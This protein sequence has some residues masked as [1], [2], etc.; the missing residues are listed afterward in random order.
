MKRDRYGKP[1]DESDQF[2][3]EDGEELDVPEDETTSASNPQEVKG[4]YNPAILDTLARSNPALIAKYRKQIA[5][6]DDNV[7]TAKSRQRMGD[8]ANTAGDLMNDY[9]N[10]QK[11]DVILKNKMSNLGNSPSINKAT[12]PEYE[13]KISGITSRNLAQANSDRAKVDSEFKND[14]AVNELQV[15]SA[16][17]ADMNDPASGESEQARNYLKKV[18]PSASNY[19]NL[20][21]MSAAQIEKIVPGLY[22]KYADDQDNVTKRATLAKAK[23]DK[24]G[25]VDS[26]LVTSEQAIAK[27]YRSHPVTKA[28]NEVAAAYEKVKRAAA[29]TSAAG[30]LSLIFGYMKMLDPGSTVREGEFATA[31]NATGIPTQAVNM[32]NKALTGERLAD[33]QRADFLRQSKN[34]YD[35]QAERQEAIRQEYTGALGRYGLD[36]ERALGP[37]PKVQS[38]APITP[39]KGAGKK[40]TV[41]GVKY[42]VAEDGDTLIPVK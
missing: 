27:E 14:I 29:D 32:Y 21:K 16:K 34:V 23:E 30:D 2:Y 22:K 6:K 8:Y 35:A 33:E 13:D 5:E 38:T 1:I 4:L 20:D 9:N 11:T 42:T 39:S 28:T 36:P 40:V 24:A 37:A 7:E 26:A 18:V 10:S 31:Q 3:N 25:K 41:N 17:Q 19:P 12:R 15:N